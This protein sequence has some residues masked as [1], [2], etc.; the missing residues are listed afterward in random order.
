VGKVT[1]RE[2]LSF[3]RDV[4]LTSGSCIECYREE[5]CRETRETVRQFADIA[6][7]VD[8]QGAATC[9]GVTVKNYDIEI[10]NQIQDST[11]TADKNDMVKNEKLVGSSE[12]G[13]R[14]TENLMLINDGMACKSD[15]KIVL[16]WSIISLYGLLNL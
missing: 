5:D 4:F 6:I 14:L 2:G 9:H 15:I 3:I 8:T 13:E 11:K 7:S 1:P 16:A 10:N 12:S